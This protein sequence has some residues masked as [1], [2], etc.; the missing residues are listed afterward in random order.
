MG[1]S[2][3]S[4]ILAWPN[5]FSVLSYSNFSYGARIAHW[6]GLSPTPLL[7]NEV[8]STHRGYGGIDS[9]SSTRSDL[10]SGRTM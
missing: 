3:V 6:L 5:A 1:L 4:L 8:S 7:F 9:F 2:A 10:V